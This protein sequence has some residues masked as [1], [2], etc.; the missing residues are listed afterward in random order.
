MTSSPFPLLV[1][2][3]VT[4]IYSPLLYYLSNKPLALKQQNAFTHHAAKSL[5]K[6]LSTHHQKNPKAG[7]GGR[8]RRQSA[9]MGASLPCDVALWKKTGFLAPFGERSE[10]WARK[11]FPSSFRA[12]TG[13]VRTGG[14]RVPPHP[15]T[16]AAVLLDPAE[17]DTPCSPPG[18]PAL[19]CFMWGSGIM[20]GHGDQH[21]PRCLEN[22]FPISRFDSPGPWGN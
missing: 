10:S 9:W 11:V 2:F 21:H 16:R 13:E 6:N 15:R 22:I 7:A 12:V 14:A 18:A 3:I 20:P 1:L 4:L 5:G 19:P 8:I 17:A